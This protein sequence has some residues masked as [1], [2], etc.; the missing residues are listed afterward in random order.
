MREFFKLYHAD[1]FPTFLERYIPKCRRFV[2]GMGNKFVNASDE[3]LEAFVRHLIIAFYL[4]H[5]DVERV[6]QDLDSL[7]NK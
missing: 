4:E 2:R 6:D 3:K 5:G 7:L 1:L